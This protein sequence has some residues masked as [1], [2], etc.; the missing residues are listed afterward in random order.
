[1]INLLTGVPGAG[2]T[3]SAIKLVLDLPKEIEKDGAPYTR[4]VYYHHI[5]GCSISEWTELNQ[6]QVLAWKQLPFGSI[7]LIDEAHQVFPQRTR[8]LAPE[9]I[10]DLD[11]HR[12]HGFDFYLVTQSPRKVDVEVRRL[13]GRH[14]HFD[15]RFG[16]PRI[17]RYEFQRCVDDPNDRREQVQA[18]RVSV[19]LDKSIY[20]LYHSAEIH[21]HKFR[22][23]L[24]IVAVGVLI[25][26]V[27]P[28]VIYGAVY[29][30]DRLYL[31]ADDDASELIDLADPAAESEQRRAVRY[32]V[33]T[34]HDFDAAVP[35]LIDSRIEWG[36]ST[37]VILRRGGLVF[38]VNSL[39]S[40]GFVY[41]DISDCS[42][43]VVDVAAAVSYLA[44]CPVAARAVDQ[45]SRD[46]AAGSTDSFSE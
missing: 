1:M 38:S 11:E 19:M 41:Y 43:L 22:V 24:K 39:R 13:V 33:S 2:K 35:F 36:A 45:P 16:S 28:A 46:P 25:L 20:G 26:I 17:S 9:F 42:G 32:L 44:A 21:T 15:R 12:H 37:D 31:S 7:I 4:P 40:L 5:D 14:Y 23:P 18:V 34:L 10:R 8:G 3:L 30:I 27:L 6:D 29:M